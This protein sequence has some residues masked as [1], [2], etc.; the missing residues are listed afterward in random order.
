MTVPQI[1]SVVGAVAVALLYLKDMWPI[2]LTPKGPDTLKHVRNILAVRDA[3][4]SP[5]VAARCNALMEALLGVK[6]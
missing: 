6:P 5:E 2:G 1:I 4:R 3:Y